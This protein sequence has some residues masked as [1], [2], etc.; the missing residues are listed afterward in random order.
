MS[1]IPYHTLLACHKQISPKEKKEFVTR[2]SEGQKGPKNLQFT[3]YCVFQRI[4][5]ALDLE[6]FLQKQS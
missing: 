6:R 2:V 3:T 1:R 4:M 5:S